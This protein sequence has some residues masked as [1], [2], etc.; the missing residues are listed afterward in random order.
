[1]KRLLRF[2]MLMV[3]T[4]VLVT[5]A[6][7]GVV[8]MFR[9]QELPMQAEL[10]PPPVVVDST[11]VDSLATQE[12]DEFVQDSLKVATLDSTINVVNSKQAQLFLQQDSLETLKASLDV[13]MRQQMA[14]QQDQIIKLASVFDAMKADQAAAVLQNMD[15]FVILA[16]LPNLS[17]RQA[18]LVMGALTPARAQELTEMLAG[19]P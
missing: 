7:T 1:M 11:L 19:N 13:A 2:I 8:W 17:D 6:V 16:I 5:A 18:A 4:F 3:V 9:D 10:M 14:A 12:R 15:D